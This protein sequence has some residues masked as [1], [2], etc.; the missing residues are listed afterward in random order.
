M[1]LIGW[2]TRWRASLMALAAMAAVSP[3][4]ARANES[5]TTFTVVVRAF[6]R[7][8]D[9]STR[10]IAVRGESAKDGQLSTGPNSS[11][12]I[13]FP[14]G[15]RLC[16]APQSN[17]SLDGSASGGL[18][19]VRVIL[20]EGFFHMLPGIPPHPSYA[21]STPYGEVDPGGSDLYC[22]VSANASGIA[23]LVR[24]GTATVRNK[25]SAAPSLIRDGDFW[26]KVEGLQRTAAAG[27]SVPIVAQIT[28]SDFDAR[29]Q[30]LDGMSDCGTSFQTDS[31][32]GSPQTI[33]GPDPSFNAS[34]TRP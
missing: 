13:L 28:R 34:P 16:L 2:E 5:P 1:K 11:L 23:C 10:E 31:V 29:I 4:A 9:A 12:E 30:Q 22:A 21:I 3:A 32:S 18:G 26:S 15:A 27:A 24:R 19:T 33:V 6:P 7:T 20:T 8:G 25:D 14:D 17:L